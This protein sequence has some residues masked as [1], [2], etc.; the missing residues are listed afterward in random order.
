M[1][2][3]KKWT[4]IIAIVI[5][6]IG[7]RLEDAEHDGTLNIVCTTSMIGDATRAIADDGMSVHTLMG[8]GVDPHLYKPSP[9]VVTRLEKADIIIH[10]GLH[11]EGKMGDLFNG[12][13]DKK[14]IIQMSDGIT[15][16]HFLPAQS[17]TAIYD[18]HIWFDVELWSKAIRHLG[19]KLAE[20]EHADR[21]AIE[22]STRIYVDTLSKLHHWVQQQIASIPPEN[23]VMITSHDAFRYFGRAYGIEVQGLQGIS[24][25]AEF[26]LKDITAM[27]NEIVDRKIPAVFIESSVSDRSMK[28]VIEGCSRKGFDLQL[29][30]TLYSDAMGPDDSPAGHYP[31]MIRHNVRTIVKALLKNEKDSS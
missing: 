18:P 13:K 28:A 5:G 1:M 26:G 23:R 3:L 10:N 20:V 31:G 8:P 2:Q 16:T 22:Q 12:L 7:C 24:T 9:D 15:Q 19:R 6:I 25:V 30:G 29:G 21:T 17:D 27:V 4:L 14:V 11:L